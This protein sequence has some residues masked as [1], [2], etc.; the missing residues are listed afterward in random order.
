[1]R[2][3]KERLKMGLLLLGAGALWGCASGGRDVG[4][5]SGSEVAVNAPDYILRAR[6]PARVPPWAMDFQ[7][8]KRSNDGPGATYFLGESGDTNERIAGC[9]LATLMATR[10]IARQVAQQVSS[11]LG[12][13]KTG[14]L[15]TDKDSRSPEELGTHF[16]DVVAAESL[17]FLTGVQDYGSYWEERDYTPSGGKKRVYVCQSVVM[18]DDA[19]LRDAM[20]R[21][22]NDIDA[23][24]SD[25]EAKQLV[26]GAF[27]KLDQ[28]FER[29]ASAKST[30]ESDSQSEE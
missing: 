22:G 24:V 25:P 6:Y 18:I 17:V 15:L 29:R 2:M 10:K 20:R 14:L 8:F 30:P 16:Q 26:K 9:E 21:V 1:M 4:S 27:K 7:A 12:S 3:S 28:S 5:V 13:A 23:K 19:H 11:E